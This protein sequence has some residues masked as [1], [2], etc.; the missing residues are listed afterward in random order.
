MSDTINS[1]IN[2]NITMDIE[3]S[4][5]ENSYGTVEETEE[6]YEQYK[7]ATRERE[8]LLKRLAK[9]QIKDD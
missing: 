1:N 4:T 5:S 2:S 6:Q 9:V 7:I 3:D 8:E